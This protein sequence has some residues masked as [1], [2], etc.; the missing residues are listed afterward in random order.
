MPAACAWPRTCSSNS[1]ST[2]LSRCRPSGPGPAARTGRSRSRSARPPSSR[3]PPI[4]PACARRGLQPVPARFV[5]YTADGSDYTLAT[6]LLDRKRYS[7]QALA[8]LYHSRWGVEEHCKVVKRSL[9]LEPF[10]GQSEDLVLQELRACF[11]LIAMTRLFANHCEAGMPPA[12]G[13]PPLR[14]NFNNSLRTVSQHPAQHG[15]LPPA[16]ASEPFLPPRHAPTRRPLEAQQEE[17]TGRPGLQSSQSTAQAP[18]TKRMPLPG[19]RG[20]C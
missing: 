20:W 8:D 7:R 5:N 16:R 18:S 13:Q 1:L 14:A 12:A 6:T 11:T 19:G 3:S 9:C 17:M 4:S 2:A 10:H 15:L